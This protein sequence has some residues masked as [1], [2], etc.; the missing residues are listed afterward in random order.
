MKIEFDVIEYSRDTGV[1]VRWLDNSRVEVK[2][3]NDTVTIRGNREGLL[4]LSMHFATLAQEDVPIGA[5][6]HFDCDFGLEKGPAE[7]ILDRME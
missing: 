7:L 2:T 4:S 3:R 5:H 1:L 6:V